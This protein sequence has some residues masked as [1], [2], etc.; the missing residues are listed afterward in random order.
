MGRVLWAF[1]P[2]DS[3]SIFWRV[4]A[5]LVAVRQLRHL[6]THDGHGCSGPCNPAPRFAA[7]R[8]QRNSCTHSANAHRLSL[9]RTMSDAPSNDN[10]AISSEPPPPPELVAAGVA[11]TVTDM[12][13]E[14]PPGPLQVRLSVSVP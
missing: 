7:A 10:S 1:G 11:V 14:V 4:A 8:T 3:R 6:R 12:G 2:G 13:A 5:R 9:R